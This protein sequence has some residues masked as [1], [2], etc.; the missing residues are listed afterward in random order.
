MLLLLLL[1]QAFAEA[2]QV[3]AADI[4]SSRLSVSFADEREVQRVLAC[5]SDY[6][7]LRVRA[8]CAGMLQRVLGACFVLLPAAVMDCKILLHNCG[9]CARKACSHC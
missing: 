7:V 1:L 5:K 8:L 3:A 2:K 6:D 4:A 9:C